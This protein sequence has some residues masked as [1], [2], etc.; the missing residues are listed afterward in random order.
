MEQIEQIKR[1]EGQGVPRSQI[2]LRLGMS[3]TTVAKYADQ[4]D[5][6]VPRPVSGEG[7]KGSILDRFT[8][9]IDEILTQDKLVWR[10][11]RHT[12][13]RV[14]ERL[15]DEHGF[16]GQYSLVQRYVKAWKAQ[17]RVDSG[18]GGFNRLEWG[19]GVAQ[20]DFG[21]AD[22]TEPTG[23]SRLPYL[24]VSF[25]Y[26][27]QGFE[28]V[29][30]GETA[31]CVC[32]G[33]TDVFT[34][35]GGVPPV[36][37]FDNAAGVGRR[38]G[39]VVRETEVFRCFRLH[40]RFEARWCNPYSGHEKGH[41]ENKV[42]AVRRSLFVPVPVVDDLRVF[43]QALLIGAV[44]EDVVH[45]RKQ[46]KVAVLFAEDQR[47]LLALPT[48]RFD[49]VRWAEYVTDKY[50]IVTVD[51]VHSYS[52][53]PSMPRT[54]VV[55]GFRAHEVEILTMTGELVA[56]HP[57]SYGRRRSQQFDPVSMM[58]ALI[59]KPGA[60]TESGFRAGMPDGPGKVF[61]DQLSRRDLTDWLAGIH[62][63]AIVHGLAETQ[64]ALDWLAGQ[65]RRFTVADLATVSE[66]AAGFG[67]LRLPDEGPDL[68]CYDQA[69]LGE[70]V[71]S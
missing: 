66:R 56:T 57:R 64:E 25:P 20:V 15:R 3:R 69:F 34:T 14:W 68:G 10:K 2:A 36:V 42:G 8:P 33:L 17:D 5:F 11:Q 16:T 47:H 65:P 48:T 26:S 58:T 70:Q 35:I 53:S 51:G 12:A 45:Y 13:K 61:L 24:V 63:Q 31:E 46:E 30:R 23:V 50:G 43:N 37:V 44:D 41:V 6:G 39:E 7:S 62:D 55:V 9:T 52:V 40:H 54:R 71:S 60:W 4:E 22:F 67:L 28:Q 19:P 59:H 1:L 21:E 29:F 27:N 18:V 49:V 32:E 38:M